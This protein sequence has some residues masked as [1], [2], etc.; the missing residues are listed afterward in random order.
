MHWTMH[1]AVNFTEL[2]GQGEDDQ[3]L[4]TLFSHTLPSNHLGSK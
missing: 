2:G 1:E 3:M 4:A